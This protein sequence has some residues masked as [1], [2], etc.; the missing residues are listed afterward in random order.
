VPV[1][2]LPTAL[3][4]QLGLAE[5]AQV[6]VGQGAAT[7]VLPARHDATLAATAVRVSAGHPATAGLGPMFGALTVEKA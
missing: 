4:T 1:V 6:R 5:G 2:G 3:W 7:A